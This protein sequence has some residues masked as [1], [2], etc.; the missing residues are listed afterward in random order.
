MTRKPIATR[1][2]VAVEIGAGCPG[3]VGSSV[4]R[5]TDRE[6]CQCTRQGP[7]LVSLL[8]Q[9][10]ISAIRTVGAVP[11]AA[12]WSRS[13]VTTR[14]GRTARA[15]RRTRPHPGR[16][17]ARRRCQ[18]R[19]Q[20]AAVP[21]ARG[22]PRPLHHQATNTTPSGAERDDRSTFAL[23]DH[24]RIGRPA[25]EPVTGCRGFAPQDSSGSKGIGTRVRPCRSTATVVRNLRC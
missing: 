1:T 18:G 19:G 16:H 21:Q 17:Q 6:T 23:L 12:S 15:R 24:P 25:T 7:F 13:T 2:S 3:G 4:D 20:H 22:P 11:D 8:Q 14:C 9:G 5:A 10:T